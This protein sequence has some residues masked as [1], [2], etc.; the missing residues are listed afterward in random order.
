MFLNI[1]RLFLMAIPDKVSL[2]ISILK[3]LFA[4]P[5]LL[6]LAVLILLLSYG[7]D[8]ACHPRGYSEFHVTGMIE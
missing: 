6:R 7:S 1:R 2:I 4:A 5:A 3:L 8:C